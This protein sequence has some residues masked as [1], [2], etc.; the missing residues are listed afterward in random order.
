[1]HV[2]NCWAR[3]SCRHCRV[4]LAERR[5]VE[6][7]YCLSSGRDGFAFG[8]D[9]GSHL[10]LTFLVRYNTSVTA[11]TLEFANTDVAFN[12]ERRNN[13]YVQSGRPDMDLLR[14][15]SICNHDICLR[16]AESKPL[17]R[18]A[19]CESEVSRFYQ[20]R[21]RDIVVSTILLVSAFSAAVIVP[22]TIWAMVSIAYRIW[23]Q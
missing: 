8:T 12:F 6:L 18:G 16:L 20:L 9:V 22:M 5:F 7:R 21:K 23:P 10:D 14:F 17:L 13:T 3:W 15:D 11:R 1:M 2:G 19:N 4:S